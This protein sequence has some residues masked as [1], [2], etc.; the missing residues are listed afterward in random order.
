MSSWEKTGRI[1]LDIVRFFP[2][3]ALVKLSSSA[4]HSGSLKDTDEMKETQIRDK[5]NIKIMPF[6]NIHRCLRVARTPGF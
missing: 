3:P 5:T 4:I 2:R 1:Q 6:I